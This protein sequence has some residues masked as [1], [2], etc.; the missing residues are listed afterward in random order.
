MQTRTCLNLA[1]AVLLNQKQ[2]QIIQHKHNKD[3]HSKHVKWQV[4]INI[5]ADELSDSSGIYVED[6]G[7]VFFYANSPAIAKLFSIL[8]LLSGSGELWIFRQSVRN[9][10]DCL[11][12]FLRSVIHEYFWRVIFRKYFWEIFLKNI[13][14]TQH[15]QAAGNIKNENYF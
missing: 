3:Y 12:Y 8:K 2:Q 9:S 5:D 7:C 15:S 6:N 14:D 1:P 10:F 11:F 13:F 4:L